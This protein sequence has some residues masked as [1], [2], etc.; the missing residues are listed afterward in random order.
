[1][2]LLLEL[3]LAVVGVALNWLPY[4]IPEWATARSRVKKTLHATYKVL[5][6]LGLFP[7]TWL[8]EAWLAS[9]FLSFPL[10]PLATG[11]LAPLSGWIALR[12]TERL[13]TMRSES[14]AYL[15]LRP[16]S[17]LAREL[18]PRRRD[19][20]RRLAEL[21]RYPRKPSTRPSER[22]EPPRE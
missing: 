6:S 12:F 19:I 3:P 10:A 11:V 7:L 1:M 14:R 20:L 18:E 5:L 21:D 13:D 16:G 8:A 2:M 15:A 9:R 22:A 17:A 4:K